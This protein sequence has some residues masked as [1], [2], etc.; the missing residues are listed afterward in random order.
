MKKVCFALVICFF[1]KRDSTPFPVRGPEEASLDA[2]LLLTTSDLGVA[3]ARQMRSDLGNFDKEEYIACLVKFLG[4]FNSTKAADDG[5]Y[6]DE[7]GGLPSKWEDL[8]RRAMAKSR[9]VPIMDFM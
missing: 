7:D 1:S 2:S 8:G 4:G 9:K 6:E 3:K 5:E